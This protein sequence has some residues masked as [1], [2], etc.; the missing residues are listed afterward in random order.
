LLGFNRLGAT[1]TPDELVYIWR[2]NLA[3]DVGPGSSPVDAA[4][5]NASVILGVNNTVTEIYR[6]GL[7]KAFILSV[8]GVAN[9]ADLTKLENTF[10]TRLMRGVKSIFEVLAVRADVTP[11]IISSDIKESMPIEMINAANEAIATALGVP[12]SL[13]KS[14]ALAG[15]TVDADRL[16]FYD[17]TIVPECN[18]IAD[19]LNDQYYTEHGIELVFEPDE[20]EVYQSTQLAQAVTVTQLTGGKPILTVDEAREYI[21]EEPNPEL[22]S[23]PQAQPAPVMPQ[24]D[25]AQTIVNDVMPVDPVA[26]EQAKLKRY[27]HKRLGSDKPFKFTSNII[28]ARDIESVRACKSHEEIEA[29]TFGPR[30]VGLDVLAALN[31]A[32][33]EAKRIAT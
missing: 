9:Q 20:L 25:Q 2:Q 21:G 15:G 18:L 13:V 5:A 16:S 1:L 17:F 19:A 7:L 8:T 14:E 12:Q 33:A 3:C 26:E 10:R 28:P 31:E 6:S 11:Q 27:A 29:V 22:S 4:L 23:M 30:D 32:I 24:T